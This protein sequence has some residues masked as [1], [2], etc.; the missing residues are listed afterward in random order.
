REEEEDFGPLRLCR[1]RLRRSRGGAACLALA[2]LRADDAIHPLAIELLRDEG[3][4]ELLSDGAGEETPHRVLLPPGLLHDGRDRRSLRAA[5]HRDHVGLF[6]IGTSPRRFG[7]ATLSCAGGG[8]LTPV[9]RR[10]DR[11]LGRFR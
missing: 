11:L 10:R 5:Q 4:A 6:G 8:R 1:K 9:C 2:S 3:E 7:F